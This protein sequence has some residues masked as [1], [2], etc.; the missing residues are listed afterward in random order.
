M[1]QSH[2]EGTDLRH[3]TDRLKAAFPTLHAAEVQTAIEKAATE[4]QDARIKAFLPI[5]IERRAAA[6]LRRRAHDTRPPK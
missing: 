5:L 3:L 6:T 1:D 2:S 4:L